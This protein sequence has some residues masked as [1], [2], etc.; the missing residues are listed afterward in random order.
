M[1]AGGPVSGLGSIGCEVQGQQFMVWGAIT[2]TITVQIMPQARATSLS[3]G[4]VGVV[5]DCGCVFHGQGRGFGVEGLGFRVEGRGLRHVPF[6]GVLK[7]LKC[8]ATR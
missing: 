1:L 7:F 6:P 4:Q 3:T 8:T 2:A 5:A